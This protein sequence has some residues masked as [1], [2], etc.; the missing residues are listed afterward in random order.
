MNLDKTLKINKSKI[1]KKLITSRFI[2]INFINRS[3]QHNLKQLQ[4]EKQRKL[5]QLEFQSENIY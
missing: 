2:Y 4:L 1:M 3:P 5:K